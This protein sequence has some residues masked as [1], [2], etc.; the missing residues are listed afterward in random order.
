MKYRKPVSIDEIRSYLH[1]CGEGTKLYFGCDSERFRVDGVWH[2]DFML[3]LVIHR[4]GQHGCK[5]FGEV[6]RERDFDSKPSKPSYRLM[7]EAYR[8]AEFYHRLEDLLIEFDFDYELHLDINSDEKAGSNIVLNQ[9]IGY[10][11][12]T[13][14]V[15]P[16]YKPNA[17][18]ASYASDRLKYLRG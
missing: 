12:G 8:L 11:K 17:F 3:V 15:I 7:S 2:N 10:I 9:A 4:E 14:N 13:C 1:T 18:A 5:I 6:Q 16:M